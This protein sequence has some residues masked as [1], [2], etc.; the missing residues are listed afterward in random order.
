MIH[1][2]VV[3]R[4]VN[5]L[6]SHFGSR[7]RVRPPATAAE[8][9]EL[10]RAVGQLPRDLVIFFVTCNGLRVTADG[11]ES[12]LHL[13]HL[14]EILGLIRDCDGAPIVAGFVPIRGDRCA[15]RDCIVISAGPAHGAVIRRDPWVPGAEFLNS[16]FGR[17]FDAWTNYL[18]GTYDP[19]GHLYPGE[20]VAPFDS[21]FTGRDDSKVHELNS[22]D[23]ARIWLR[24]LDGTVSS[25]ADFE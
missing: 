6:S 5:R 11:I 25:G 1:E 9:A 4:C 17:Y 7:L 16:S 14:A 23:E 19:E 22:S 12:D 10:E 15:S 18:I 8:L 21:I 2:S 3:D 13:W 20:I 24:R